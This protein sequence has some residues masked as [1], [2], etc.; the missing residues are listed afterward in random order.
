MSLIFIANSVAWHWIELRSIDWHL[1]WLIVASFLAGT[2]NAVAGGG[3]FLSFPAMLSVGLGPIQANATN[4]VAL[5]PGQLTS[6]AGYWNDVKKHSKLA[7]RMSVAG[8]VGGSAGAIVLL[9]TP[10]T[11]FLHLVPWLLLVAALIF[12]ASGP[13]MNW[14]KRRATLRGQNLDQNL[15]QQAASDEPR[16]LWLLIGATTIVCFYVGYFGAG[17][18]FLI[19]SL[20]SLF[21]FQDMNE[22][23]AM[24]VVSTTMANGMACILFVFSG[25]VEWRYCLAAMVTCAIGGYLSAR[26]SQRMNPRFLRGLVV[27]IGLGMAAYFFWRN[28]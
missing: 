15:D 7:V 1:P 10:A 12:A 27:F 5:W 6:I 11:T 24:K 14:L 13:V 17:A 18:G 8:L 9:N 20:L 28:H 23:N 21:G 16:G 2:L 19:I 3:S 22:M 25:K 26:I 4:T